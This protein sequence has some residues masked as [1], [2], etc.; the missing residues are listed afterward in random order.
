M[1]PSFAGFKVQGMVAPGG[2]A[3][4]HSGNNVYIAA[5]E[6]ARGPIYAGVNH[7]EQRSQNAAFTIKSTFA[8]ANVDYGHGKVYAGFY[9]GNNNGSNAATNV[10]GRY[11][12]IWSLSADWRISPAATAAI[13]GGFTDADG[14]GGP[15]AYEIGAAATYSLSK[16]TF[17]YSSV[18][19]LQNRRG[20]TFSLA[21]AG[22]VSR[23]TPAPGGTET[24]VQ[25]G[26]RHAF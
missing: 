18:A 15:Q 19:R 11:F 26:I 10:Q 17:L 3:D 22:P 12:D 16:T 24:G 5:L 13:G 4:P 6:Y 7:V 8:G 21:G 2:Q 9:R 25:I 14:H 23:N 20:G 1:S